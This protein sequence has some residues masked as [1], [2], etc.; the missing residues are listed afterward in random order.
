MHLIVEATDVETAHSI[1]EAVEAELGK[2]FS[3]VRILIHVEPPQYKSEQITY[4]S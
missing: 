4:E 1:T 2:E 3:P